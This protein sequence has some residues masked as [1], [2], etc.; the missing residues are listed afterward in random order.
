VVT[1]D[2]QLEVA[3]AYLDLLRAYGALSINDEAL[4]KAQEMDRAAEA[5][6]RRGLG[7]TGADPNRARTEV[8]VRRQ[9]RLVLQEQAAGASARLAQLLLSDSSADLIPCDRTVLPITLVPVEGC[10]DDLIAVALMNRPELAEFRALIRVALMRWT[11]AKYQPLIP[12]L[13]AYYAGGSFIGGQPV[14]N[15]A[16]GRDDV[17][18]QVSWNLRNMGF[19]NLFQA[20]ERKAQYDEATYRLIEEEAR[21]ADEVTAAAK[22]CRARLA[23]VAEA[24]TAVRNAEEMWRKLE[25][26]AFGVGLP[27]GEYDP[28]EAITAERALLEARTLYLDHVIGYNRNQFRLFWA[29]GQPPEEAI[30]K[31]VVRPV[32]IPVLPSPEKTKKAD[33]ENKDGEK[34]KKG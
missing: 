32:I 26:I 8:E 22:I 29:M 17:I 14:L 19:G 31:A 11:Q 7:K 1:N 10:I 3:M 21:V 24:Q 4:R 5:A 12:L 2:I 6:F 16:S 34:K 13:Q 33:G 27:A 15:T 30:P 25:A 28:L 20:R 9:E 18:V 23:A